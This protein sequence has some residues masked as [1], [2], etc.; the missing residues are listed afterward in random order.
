MTCDPKAAGDPSGPKNVLVGV[1]LH[2]RAAVADKKRIGSDGAASA[3]G[4]VQPGSPVLRS[5]HIGLI[6]Q[7]RRGHHMAALTTLAYDLNHALL[8]RQVGTLII[9]VRSDIADR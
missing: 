8:R 2:Y 9:V 1:L 6:E 5:I 4:P 7:A 3:R